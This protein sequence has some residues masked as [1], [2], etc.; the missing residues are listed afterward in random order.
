MNLS[1]FEKEFKWRNMSVRMHGVDDTLLCITF[2]IRNNN[3][4]SELS[5]NRRFR[6]RVAPKSQLEG[7]GKSDSSGNTQRNVQ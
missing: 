4:N 1:T 5:H 6:F 3:M 2:T 7:L